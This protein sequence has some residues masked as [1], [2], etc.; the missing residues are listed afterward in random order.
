MVAINHAQALLTDLKSYDDLT[1]DQRSQMRRLLMCVAETAGAVAKLPET[2]AENRRFLNNLRTD[3][4]DTVE[5]A[6]TWIIVAVALALSLGTMVGWRRVA[7]TIVRRSA[8]KA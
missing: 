2:S 1:V 8:K 3:L 4:L 7:V 6:P 5:Y